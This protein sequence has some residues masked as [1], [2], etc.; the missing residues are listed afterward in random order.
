MVSVRWGICF[1]V[2]SSHSL[3][4]LTPRILTVV[5]WLANWCSISS[6]TNWHIGPSS[7]S[8]VWS[9]FSMWWVADLQGK[10]LA[11]V[12]LSWSYS[13]AESAQGMKPLG[14]VDDRQGMDRVGRIRMASG[15]EAALDPNIGGGF[16][17][18][19]RA[20]VSCGSVT[21]MVA[22]IACCCCEQVS[23]FQRRGWVLVAT[24]AMAIWSEIEHAT[25]TKK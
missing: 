15:T 4:S 23:T 6:C 1:C 21:G 11:T 12:T 5:D 10:K 16:L 13:G 22:K 17:M 20:R 25:T 9:M 3:M 7:T 14:C 2:S 24:E 8:T 18:A 19:A